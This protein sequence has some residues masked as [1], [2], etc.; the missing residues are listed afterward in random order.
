MQVDRFDGARMAG[1]GNLTCI[2]PTTF[3]VN[4]PSL[5]LGRQGLEGV[6]R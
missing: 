6:V 3:P 4:Y 5:L 2:Y 1:P